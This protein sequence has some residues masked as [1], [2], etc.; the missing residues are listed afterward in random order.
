MQN[1]KGGGTPVRA[2]DRDKM[3]RAVVAELASVI[4]HVRKS[5]KLI[6]SAIA[7]DAA[8]EDG[9]ADNVIVLDDVTPGYERVDAALRECDT[10]LSVALRLLQ[11]PEVSGNAAAAGGGLPPTRLPISA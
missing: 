6:E 4:E 3:Y 1:I 8:A 10:G 9:A 11:G 5:R 2:G 7:S